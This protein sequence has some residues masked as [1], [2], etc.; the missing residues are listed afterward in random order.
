[1]L[2]AFFLLSL[3]ALTQPSAETSRPAPESLNL[4]VAE[5]PRANLTGI[6]RADDYPAEAI[7]KREQ[8]T[9]AVRIAVNERGE[10]TG[11]KVETS[12]GSPTLDAQTCKIVFARARFAPAK[13]SAGRLVAGEFHQRIT[14]KLEDAVEGPPLAT[15]PELARLAAEL[16]KATKPAVLLNSGEIARSMDYPQDAL[17]QNLEGRAHVRLLVDGDGQVTRCWVVE[18][19]GHDLLDAQTCDLYTANAKFRPARDRRGR[20]VASL[21]DQRLHWKL[22]G[23]APKTLANWITRVTAVLGP[24]GE[25]RSCKAEAFIE[26]FWHEGPPEMCEEV[27]ESDPQLRRA[28]REKSKLHDAVVVTETRVLTEATEVMPNVGRRR[29]EVLVVLRSAR[30]SFTPDGKRTSCLTLES[31]GFEGQNDVCAKPSEITLKPPPEMIGK[32]DL[33]VRLLNAIYLSGEP[34]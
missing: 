26:G 3:V 5:G 30:M 32:A 6:I 21:F 1:M 22:E 24:E 8:G 29:G 12:S 4:G 9:V 2:R 33:D 34:E 18:S 19:S 10:V 20:T 16:P 25:L 23:A 27:G 15:S 11:C 17:R 7:A 28:V 14:W 13:D 31:I